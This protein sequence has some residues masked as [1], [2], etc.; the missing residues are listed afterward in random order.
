MY[1]NKQTRLFSFGRSLASRV[2]LCGW[3]KMLS[4]RSRTRHEHGTVV[5]DGCRRTAPRGQLAEP[6]REAER[7]TELRLPAHRLLAQL[8]LALGDHKQAKHHA[9]AA[10]RWA[11]AD[12]EPY[13]H[14]YEL[15]KTTE[16]LQKLN[17]PIPNL[18][19]YDPAKDEPFP[20]EADV[21]AT[22]EKLR[23]EKES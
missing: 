12:G 6:Q 1:A 5:A 9:L 21:R 22:I 3:R 14:R 19:S 13:V 8:W 4:Q 2:S 15:T 7:L 20:C 16:L 17:V 11:W 18:P 23:A 10:Y